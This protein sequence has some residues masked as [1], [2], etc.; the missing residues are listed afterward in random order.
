M[1]LPLGL[2]DG[3]D[4]NGDLGVPS[5]PPAFEPRPPPGRP[6]AP[7]M[8]DQGAAGDNNFQSGGQAVKFEV[9]VSDPQKQGSGMNAFV[10]SPPP[11][12]STLQIPV[13]AE[14]RTHRE[15]TAS[16][17]HQ[18]EELSPRTHIPR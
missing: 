6:S 18:C 12:H 9:H 7:A 14:T 4:D 15:A 8:P 10:R 13:N 3:D 17:S 1:T 16:S 5:A 2:G 11:E